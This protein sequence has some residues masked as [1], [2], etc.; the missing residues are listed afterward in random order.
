[1]DQ[2]FAFYF[3]PLL[4]DPE[5]TRTTGWDVLDMTRE[6]QRQGAITG[7]HPEWR[8]T[9]VN[10]AYQ[11]CPTYPETLI[12][13]AKIGDAVL[14]HAARF[15]S[16]ARLPVLTFRHGV[17]GACLLRSSQP[18][19]GLTFN[20]SI[21]DERLV[22]LAFSVQ[23][24]AVNNNHPM[25]WIVDA[26]PTANAVANV[27]L[28]T[29]GGT[30]NV[31]NYKSCEKIHLPIENI[32]VMRDSLAKVMDALDDECVEDK[33]LR[34]LVQRLNRSR[35][36]WLDHLKEILAGT[37]RIVKAMSKDYRHVLIHCSDG[38]DRTAQ[39][40]A[41]VQL[42]LDPYFRTIR[43]FCTLIEK[44]WCAFG[45][46]F[47]DRCGHR[48]HHRDFTRSGDLVEADTLAKLTIE[49]QGSEGDISSTTK[50][51][52]TLWQTHTARAFNFATKT[53]HQQSSHI[54]ESSPV[55][56]QFLDSCYQIW[57]Q[58]PAR[59]EWDERLLIWLHDESHRCR[60]GTFLCNSEKERVE[61]DLNSVREKT[62]SAWGYILTHKD[63]FV[64]DLWDAA[65]DENELQRTDQG[66]L[67]VDP[68]LVQYWTG[69][70]ARG[71]DWTVTAAPP[72]ANTLAT[73]SP[74]SP[75]FPDTVDVPKDIL[76]KHFPADLASI[77]SGDPLGVV[78]SLP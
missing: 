53:L 35:S 6:F 16:K 69:L 12:V 66:V 56:L 23:H 36:H 11:L 59:F 1:M 60:F 29:G 8:I 37:M 2:C 4:H 20:R 38:W 27:A 51:L 52:Q 22:E 7:A 70:F 74:Q 67:Q 71:H 43:G 18:M 10:T 15:R 62:W 31:E 3:H 68:R 54:R 40:T 14:G 57:R 41:L 46:K 33:S 61:G 76:E 72:S 48:G 28:G 63:E 58:H 42:C 26:R 47:R 73:S 78:S 65:M 21:Q 39:L 75:N 17:T 24:V 45:H 55:F 64:N 49:R 5:W 44:D 34:F 19:V 9:H 30:E 25:N 13:P 32:H 50:T 77:T